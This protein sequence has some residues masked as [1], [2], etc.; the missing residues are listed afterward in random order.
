MDAYSR[1]VLNIRDDLERTESDQKRNNVS[2]VTARERQG[3]AWID[4]RAP[5]EAIG[6]LAK[7]DPFPCVKPDLGLPSERKRPL[8]LRLGSDR[9]PFEATRELPER[10]KPTHQNA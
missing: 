7:V 1:F 2:D 6:Q 8:T 10:K 9:R 5:F 3:K 4:H